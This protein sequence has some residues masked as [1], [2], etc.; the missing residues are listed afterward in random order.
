M[1]DLYLTLRISQLKVAS[2]YP[3]AIIRRVTNAIHFIERIGSPRVMV[4]K[5]QL[6]IFVTTLSILGILGV[7]TVDVFGAGQWS[8][9]GPLQQGGIGLGLV[10]VLVG[11]ILVRLGDRPA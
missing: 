9:L 8:G 2:A 1:L 4:T 11:V 10:G 5:R 7:V 3:Y 6:G